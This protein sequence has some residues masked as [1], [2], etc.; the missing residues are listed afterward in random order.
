MSRTTADAPELDQLAATFR[1][2]MAALGGRVHP[3][4]LD[5]DLSMPQVKALMVICAQAPVHG[6]GL[7]RTLCVGQPAV[8]KLVDHLVERGYVRREEDVDDRRVVWLRPTPRGQALRERLTIAN[9]ETLLPLLA[10]L[11]PDEREVVAGACDILIRAAERLAAQRPEPCSDR[12]DS[13]P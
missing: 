1:R 13:S 8:S 4:W 2:L 3:A 6:R 12:P 11:D 5:V 7:S 10:E 9:R